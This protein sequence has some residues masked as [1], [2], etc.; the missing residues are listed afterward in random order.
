MT[1][2]E[3][4]S[5]C[6]TALGDTEENEAA[7]KWSDNDYLNVITA[8]VIDI[9]A[10]VPE[11]RLT[12]DGAMAPII[13]D[14]LT[15]GTEIPLESSYRPALVDYVC[16]RLASSDAGDDQDKGLAAQHEQS[17]SRFMAPEG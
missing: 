1:A 11:T 2:A 4:I 13:T 15:V 3:I 6:R 8:G 5:S 12:E 14:T 10:R 17:Y 9:Q 7:Q 16:W